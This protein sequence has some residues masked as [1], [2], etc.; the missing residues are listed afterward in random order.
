MENKT[1]V[2]CRYL[3]SAKETGLCEKRKICLYPEELPAC[4]CF[5]QRPKMTNGDKIRQ[6]SNEELANLFADACP[7]KMHKKCRG[8]L[9]EDCFACWFEWLESELKGEQQ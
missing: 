8:S 1:C 2:A 6:M 9:R 4:N 3:G 5:E 7:P